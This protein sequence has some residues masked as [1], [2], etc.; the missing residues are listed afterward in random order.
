MQCGKEG[1]MKAA[2]LVTAFRRHERVISAG[3]LNPMRSKISAE[4]CG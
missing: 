3:I 1:F 4:I 2:L